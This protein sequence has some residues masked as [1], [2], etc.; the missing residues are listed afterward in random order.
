MGKELTAAYKKLNG[1]YR[2]IKELDKLKSAFISTVSHELKTPL[3]IIKG[4]VALLKIDKTISM[5]SK[6]NELFQMLQN[7]INRLQTIIDD[8]L[9]LSKIESGIFPV[10]KTRSDIIE[11]IENS[12]EELLPCVAGRNIKIIKKYD[13]QPIEWNFDNMRIAR[14]FNNILGNA[15]KFSPDNSS[16]VVDLKII[17]GR[18]IEV[19]YYLDCLIYFKKNYLLFSV[20]DNGIGIEK[21]YHE[22]IF[23]K[24]FQIED[25]L[26][27]KYQGAGIG[28]SIAKAIVEAHDGLIWCESEGAGKGSTFYVLLPE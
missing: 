26:T 1:N 16:I 21:Q 14:V 22:K 15:I 10:K 24:M 20:S 11:V 5:D 18:D 12:I 28:L 9:D 2:R 6:K 8:L 19:P 7:S 4:S 3:T 25:P 17:K 23:E 13:N 27:R